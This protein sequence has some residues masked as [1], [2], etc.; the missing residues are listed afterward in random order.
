[1][2]VCRSFMKQ[3]FQSQNYISYGLTLLFFYKHVM[4]CDNSKKKKL[5]RAEETWISVLLLPGGYTV[6]SD[7][8][9]FSSPGTTG[10]LT[11]LWQLLRLRLN[12]Q[13]HSWHWWLFTI[14]LGARSSHGFHKIT[15]LISCGDRLHPKW[16]CCQLEK[17]LSSAIMDQTFQEVCHWKTGLAMGGMNTHPSMFLVPEK[18][19]WLVERQTGGWKVERSNARYEFTCERVGP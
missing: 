7:G 8:A 6:P 1:M 15:D 4:P 10:I 14:K 16:C 18:V 5:L 2:V 19:L 12:D 11:Y 3:T 9:S 13:V 17:R